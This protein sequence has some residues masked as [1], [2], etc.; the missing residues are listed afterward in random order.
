MLPRSV[1]VGWVVCAL[2]CL[3][4]FG[5]TT[6]ADTYYVA[7]TGSD[8]RNGSQAAP[9]R[10]IRA[11]LT[12]V[13]PG[14]TILVGDGDYL[15]FTVDSL[16]GTADAPITIRALG[17]GARVLPTTDRHDN[18]DTIFIT[19]S[20]YV[21]VDGLRAFKANRAGV[22]VNHSAHIT[23]KNG[24]FGDN[25]TWGIFTGFS[26]DLLI[27]NNK[28]YGSVRQHGIYI[29]NSCVRPTVRANYVHDNHGCGL[30]FNGD[31]SEGGAGLITGALIENN[32]IVNNGLG[33]GG[34]INMDGVQD[35]I[36][37]NNLLVNNHASGITCFRTDAAAGPRG[38]KILNNTIEMAPDARWALAI[39]AS[40]GP[41]LVRNNI[42]L[43]G[44]KAHGGILYGE[45]RDIANT[46][47]D[48]NI[49]EKITS[50]DGDT[51]L[52]LTDWQSK[53]HEAHSL[54]A[55]AESLFVNNAAGDYHLRKNAAA[56]GAG[57]AQ[58]SVSADKD[59]HPR[60][61][62]DACAIG[63]YEG[64]GTQ[65]RASQSEHRRETEGR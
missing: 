44:N 49:L 18:R 36:V 35:S 39:H 63:C 47:S 8:D 41:N 14:D 9:F 40:A 57:Q 59:G 16:Q 52:A 21:V 27:E 12:H 4:S 31:V 62:H 46:D 20:A 42:L 45:E 53:G 5:G 38:M 10:Q 22:R 15:G 34:A 60:P 58:T 51:I 6:K 65:A 19:D 33:G 25:D 30:H 37:R 55:T 56:L 29:S 13:H 17:K 1:L 32:R 48:Y 7:P 23:V 24:V 11:A 61:T 50:D 54:A 2:L 43:N 64:A 28:C 3:I 26:D